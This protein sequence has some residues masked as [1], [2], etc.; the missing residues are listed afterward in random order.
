MRLPIAI[1]AACLLLPALAVPAVAA[2]SPAERRYVIQFEAGTGPQEGAREVRGGGGQVERV[3]EHVF[4]GA[5]ARLS[6]RAASALA[7]SPRVALVEADQVVQAVETQSSAPWGLDRVDQRGLPLSGSFSWTSS[8]TGVTA[9]VVDTGVRADHVD[10]EGRVAAGYSV[11]DDGRGTGDCNGH[12][13]HVAGTIGGRTHGVAKAVRVVPVRVLNCEGSGTVS[14]VVTGLDWVVAQHSTGTPAV[15]NLSLG[16]GA[17]TSLDNAVQSTIN[18]GVSVVVAAGNS[19]VD[20][21]TASPARVGAAVTVGASDRADVRAS[22]SNYGTCLDLF[23]PGVGISSAWHTTSTATASLNGTSMAAPHVAGAAAALLQLDPAMPPAGVADRLS[24]SATTG[25]V[26]GAG[27]GSPNRLLWADPNPV[28]GSG[29]TTTA[30]A[31]PTNVE[32]LAGKRAATVS[33]TSG[34]DG[35]SALTGQTVRVYAAG[36]FVGSVSVSGLST[37]VKVGGLKAGTRYTFTVTATNAV[38]SSAESGHSNE[39][40]PTR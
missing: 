11:I 28:A 22:F 2:G 12:G 1:A 36:S 21:C 29:P 10:F 24:T 39:V 20:A 7:R 18:D 14:G 37:S 25:V 4:S 33:W 27:T 40:V 30:P 6:E 9:Y 3:L 32:A 23:A 38:G 26:M 19:N 31:A 17:S 5:V 35:G 34:S 13:T 8:G 15:A 16:G